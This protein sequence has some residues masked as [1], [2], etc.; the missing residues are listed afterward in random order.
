MVCY[1]LVPFCCGKLVEY[2][3]FME[4]IISELITYRNERDWKQFHNAKDL[5][6]ALNIESAELLEIFLWKESKK[7]DPEKIKEELADVFAYAFLLAEKYNF[8]VKELVL[9]KIQQ[10]RLKYPIEKKNGNEVY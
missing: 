7:A 9:T 1:F 4:E 8:D 2:S 6:I 10:N 5:S 3:R